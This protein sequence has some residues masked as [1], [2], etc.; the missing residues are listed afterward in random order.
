[1]G[2]FV[3]NRKKIQGLRQQYEN[4]SSPKYGY[5]EAANIQVQV[6]EE[7]CNIG[8]EEAFLEI[9]RIISF[10]ANRE[11]MNSAIPEILGEKVQLI[12]RDKNSTV[13]QS[14]TCV[15]LMLVIDLLLKAIYQGQNLTMRNESARQIRLCSSSCYEMLMNYRKSLMANE[16]DT[17]VNGQSLIHAING[18]NQKLQPFLPSPEHRW[19]GAL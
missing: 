10:G 13:L 18:L 8:S 1:M 3:N 17:L 5:N 7:L 6:I 11:Y 12:I 2:I 9:E 15:R 4:A 14:S 16:A 19:N